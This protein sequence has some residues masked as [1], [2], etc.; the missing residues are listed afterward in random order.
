MQFF[1][2]AKGVRC[3]SNVGAL[4]ID[5]CFSTFA[6]HA[7]STDKL[8]FFVTGDLSFFYDMNAAGL[9]SIGSNVRVILLN[10]GGGSEFQFFMGKKNIPTIDSYICAE[11]EKIA[12]GWI[13]S[14][15]YDY[16]LA[17]TKE[18][19]DSVIDK[20][21]KPSE[22]PM[23]LEVLTDMG[24]DADKTNAFYDKYRG[25]SSAKSEITSMI[26]GVLSD[27]QY[28]KLKRIMKI[29]KEK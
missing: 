28:N 7:A 25:G 3:Y 15:G 14:L 9:R 12:A 29:L 21:G 24:E 17:S 23:F 6:G 11:H 19:L 2:L 16:Y 20:F 10:N 18:E 13:K 27:K 22:R 4:G 26:K 5:G 1:K 8:A